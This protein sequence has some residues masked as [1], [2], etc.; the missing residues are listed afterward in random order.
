MVTALA[1]YESCHFTRGIA[2]EGDANA[3]YPGCGIRKTDAGFGGAGG[4]GRECRT[5]GRAMIKVSVMYPNT[6]G[7]RFNHEYYRDRHMPLVKARMGDS[8]KYYTIDK[9]LAGGAPGAPATYVGMCHIFC[10]SIEAFQA[11]F[12]PHAQEIMGDIPNYTDLT[13]VLQISEVVVGN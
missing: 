3:G 5:K 4:H 9:G 8:C 7:A 1:Q 11:G 10:D 2:P 6:P 13:P 12:G